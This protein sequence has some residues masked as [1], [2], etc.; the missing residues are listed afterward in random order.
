MSFIEQKFSQAAFDEL[1]LIARLD[2]YKSCYD[3]CRLVKDFLSVSSRQL[4]VLKEIIYDARQDCDYDYLKAAAKAGIL[5]PKIIIPVKS[6]PLISF[7]PNW[8][9]VALPL[10]RRTFPELV[11]KDLVSVQLMEPGQ[12]FYVD[13]WQMGA[14]KAAAAN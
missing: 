5:E 12:T 1:I 7:K 14:I 9:S 3:L 6:K 13:Q 11:A 8:E 4:E 2:S 10:V